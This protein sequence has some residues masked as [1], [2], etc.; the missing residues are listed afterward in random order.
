MRTKSL[1]TKTLK[2]KFWQDADCLAVVFR[3]VFGCLSCYPPGSLSSMKHFTNLM[4]FYQINFP[5]VM[6][7]F[8]DI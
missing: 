6:S 1:V 2:L 3:N 8:K 5:I 7:N 4:K